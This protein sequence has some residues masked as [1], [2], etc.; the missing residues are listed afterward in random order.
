MT[1]PEF[2]QA[3][4]TVEKKWNF[5]SNPFT[6]GISVRSKPGCLC[7]LVAVARSCGFDVDPLSFS[8]AGSCL[9]MSREDA[10]MIAI[11][12][13]SKTFDIYEQGKYNL[14]LLVNLRSQILEAC[15]LTE[16]A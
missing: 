6:G 5:D 7:P 1:I 13:D 3:L 15:G 11:A 14:Q 9:Q 8:K 2:I 10:R 4:K 16:A 12:A